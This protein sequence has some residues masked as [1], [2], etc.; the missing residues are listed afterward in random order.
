MR[1]LSCS[2]IE[3][4]FQFAAGFIVVYFLQDTDSVLLA[5]SEITY[6]LYNIKH[7]HTIV[8]YHG[9]SLTKHDVASVSFFPL[10]DELISAKVLCIGLPR[11]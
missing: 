2:L 8:V 1:F 9:W 11:Q 10:T 7:P 6:P 5:V 4:T 3:S